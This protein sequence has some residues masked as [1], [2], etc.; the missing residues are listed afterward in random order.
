M[1][2]NLLFEW[3]SWI[4]KWGFFRAGASELGAQ[5]ADQPSGQHDREK[6]IK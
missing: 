5:A 1:T 6:L 3:D 2:I 4:Q